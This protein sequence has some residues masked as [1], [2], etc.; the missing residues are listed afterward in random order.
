MAATKR[1]KRQTFYAILVGIVW[2]L[3][4][5]TMYTSSP[6]WVYFLMFIAG[7]VFGVWIEMAFYQLERLFDAI[8]RGEERDKINTQMKRDEYI[9]HEIERRMREERRKRDSFN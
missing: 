1:E 4:L 2:V 5:N 7:C 9:E 8:N 6:A 3:Y